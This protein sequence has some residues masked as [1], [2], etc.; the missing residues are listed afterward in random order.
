M[1]ALTE[2]LRWTAAVVV[3]SAAAVCSRNDAEA[4]NLTYKDPGTWVLTQGT[5]VAPMRLAISIG[6]PLRAGEYL[7]D[8]TPVRTNRNRIEYIP[9]QLFDVEVVN[10]DDV[11]GRAD[12]L[13]KQRAE[14]AARKAAEVMAGAAEAP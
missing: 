10:V 13:R 7:V 6:K 11:A 2:A 14:E 3:L 4:S 8:L 1:A 9:F 5:L 12:R